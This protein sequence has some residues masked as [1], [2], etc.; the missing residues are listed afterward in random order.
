MSA[1]CGSIGC[2][3]GPS[4]IVAPLPLAH[5]WIG[6]TPFEKKTM[7]RRRGGFVGLDRACR[8]AEHGQRL[9]PGQRQRDADT[10]KEV[11]PRGRMTDVIDLHRVEPLARAR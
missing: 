8:L 10:S 7:P 5:Q 1:R 6:S 11:T 9:H 3:A 4:S 2:T